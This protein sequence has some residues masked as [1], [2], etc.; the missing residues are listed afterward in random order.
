VVLTYVANSLFVVYF[1]IR[2]VILT[3]QR[4][5]ASKRRSGL[6]GTPTPSTP[7]IPSTPFLAALAAGAGTAEAELLMERRTCEL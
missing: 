4:W 6:A 5:R 2:Q 1:P 3:I 7:P